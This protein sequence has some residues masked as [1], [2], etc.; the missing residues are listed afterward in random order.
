MEKIIKGH[1][2][3]IVTKHAECR[4]IDAGELETLLTDFTKFV[5]SAL[6]DKYKRCAIR[7]YCIDCKINKKIGKHCRTQTN[8]AIKCPFIQLFLKNLK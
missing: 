8:D 1:I 2:D 4:W 5:I 3:Q 6:N 7:A